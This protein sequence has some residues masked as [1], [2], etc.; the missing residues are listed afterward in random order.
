MFDYEVK[1]AVATAWKQ[2][3]I[4]TYMK[5]GWERSE[6]YNQHKKYVLSNIIPM[7][8]KVIHIYAYNYYFGVEIVKHL[9]QRICCKKAIT[10]TQ[11]FQ[12]LNKNFS[13]SLI[14]I[15]I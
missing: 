13:V 14:N 11:F 7:Y 2:K 15:L 10:I 8:Y 5:T 9:T 3:N 4:Y 1:K 12:K 6:S